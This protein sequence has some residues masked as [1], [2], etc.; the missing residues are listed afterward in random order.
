M[1]ENVAAYQRA[2]LVDT[3]SV[4]YIRGYLRFAREHNLPPFGPQT[5]WEQTRAALP[6]NL[7][8]GY[9]DALR[10][11]YR[12][13]G[14]V[15]R[16]V[17]E[18]ATILVSPFTQLELLHGLLEGRAHQRLAE[19]NTPYRMRQRLSDLSK[20]VTFHLRT[21]DADEAVQDVD[22]MVEELREVI[23]DAVDLARKQDDL[24]E[25]L[26][27]CRVIQSSVF[28]DPVDCLI[29][30]NALVVEAEVVISNDEHLREVINRIAEP[31]TEG[32]P[33]LRP[34]WEN[35]NHKLKEK[36]SEIIAAPLA[37]IVLPRCPGIPND[38][39][40]LGGENA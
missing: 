23:G 7:P 22:K 35:A 14:F 9:Q 1:T 3:N 40:V 15:Q 2:V 27:V 36:L 11:G 4:H 33:E 5:N 16:L 39:V 37:Q 21:T 32:N 30:G 20:L 18:E 29:Y 17:T 19:A 12:T 8:A 6:Q 13:L 26:S 38:S 31:W 24:R 10:R 25:I 28:I 34:L